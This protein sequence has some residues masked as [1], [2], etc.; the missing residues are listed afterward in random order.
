MMR[1]CGPGVQV[2]HAS[3]FVM[4]TVF[5][6]M[7]AVIFLALGQEHSMPIENILGSIMILFLC[8]EVYFGGR[9]L[10]SL[11]RRQ[12]AHFYRRRHQKDALESI[13]LLDEH[14]GMGQ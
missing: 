1:E 14:D 13:G 5:P 6:Q 3:A 2:P 11:M 8:L 12:M 10:R 4:T 9:A 7:P